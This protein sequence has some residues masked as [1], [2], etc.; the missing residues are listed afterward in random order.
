MKKLNLQENNDEKE[1][2]ESN[3]DS[4][5]L[6][7]FCLSRMNLYPPFL[8]L[9]VYGDGKFVQTCKIMNTHNE[10]KIMFQY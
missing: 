7:E 5:Q 10:V 8:C 6:E 9:P 4:L 1:G 3:L 2:I